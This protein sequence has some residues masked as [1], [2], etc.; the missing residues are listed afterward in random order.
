MLP[1]FGSIFTRKGFGVGSGKGFHSFPLLWG[2]V[3]MGVGGALPPT[4]ILPHK[5]E[6][7][8]MKHG[9]LKEEPGTGLW[10]V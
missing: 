6:D 10:A 4:C 9:P 3:G 8:C 2:K 1:V 7:I 5:R